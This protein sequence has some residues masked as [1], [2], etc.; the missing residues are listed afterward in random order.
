MD[1]LSYENTRQQMDKEIQNT[2]REQIKET[3]KT[4]SKGGK[5]IF[6]KLQWMIKSSMRNE[7][8][9]IGEAFIQE[10]NKNS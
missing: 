8:K 2:D 10:W 7:W 6:R 1:R 9:K 4:K 5:I 3:R